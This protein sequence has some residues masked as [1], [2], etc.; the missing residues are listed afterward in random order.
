L[1]KK[2]LEALRKEYKEQI[3]AEEVER[4]KAFAAAHNAK[5]EV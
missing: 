3:E 2:S 1:T 5:M 4:I